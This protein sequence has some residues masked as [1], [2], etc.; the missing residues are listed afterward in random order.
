MNAYAESFLVHNFD[1]H[2]FA[3]QN[4]SGQLDFGKAACT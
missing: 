3:C 4:V 1:G 2:L